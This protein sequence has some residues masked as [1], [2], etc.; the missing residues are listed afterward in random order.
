M[1]FYT[2]LAILV[3]SINLGSAKKY[4]NK[5]R[6]IEC[7]DYGEDWEDNV[8]V[9][10]AYTLEACNKIIGNRNYTRGQKATACY[11][12]GWDQRVEFTVALR[13][14]PSRFL[15]YDECI[16]RMM[17]IFFVCRRGGKRKFHNWKFKYLHL[18]II[19]GFPKG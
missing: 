10:S 5:Y 3:A 7:F 4:H 13:T 15:T 2:V 14:F 6:P 17:P 8:E 9:A 16:H 1:R 19:H 12:I 18:N 11:N